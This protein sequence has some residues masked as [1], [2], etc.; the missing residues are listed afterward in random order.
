M[1]LCV[2]C[3]GCKRECPTGVDMARM[4]VEFLNYYHDKHGIKLRERLFAYLPRFAPK[5]RSFAFVLNLRDQIPGLA[6]LSE[7]L[8]GLTSKRALPRWRRDQFDPSQLTPQTENAQKR[9]CA[10]GGQL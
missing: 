2:S 4:K 7:M 6:K 9:S 3:K 8:L 5:L 10:A 1:D